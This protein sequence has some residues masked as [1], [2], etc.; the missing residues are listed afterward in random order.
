[1]STPADI[2]SLYT[3]K[4]L[5]LTMTKP[6]FNPTIN[7]IAAASKCTCHR[8]TELALVT[9][10]LVIPKANDPSTPT[11]CMQCTYDNSYYC[12]YNIFNKF[13][14]EEIALSPCPT[15]STPWPMKSLATIQPSNPM[16]LKLPMYS[17]TLSDLTVG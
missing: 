12:T 1:M 2:S 14:S 6:P 5:L 15:F 3:L 11:L 7:S 8:A 17:L 13:L 4:P 9:H 10:T 16:Q